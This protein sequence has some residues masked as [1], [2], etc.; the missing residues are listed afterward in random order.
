[1]CVLK[2]CSRA[3][4]LANYSPW[5]KS[6][7][8]EAK[9]GHA[10]LV[11][12]SLWW[13]SCH[14]SC[15]EEIWQRPQGQ[16]SQKF[17]PCTLKKTFAVPYSRKMETGLK[18]KLEGKKTKTPLQDMSTDSSWEMGRRKSVLHNGR[19]GELT[20]TWCADVMCRL[21]HMISWADASS[22]SGD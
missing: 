22:I 11:T 17:W 2:Q 1:M 19:Q 10:H 9:C 15:A 14:N 8:L 20:T 3:Q 4:G 7:P 5:A 21:F 16:Q 18:V 13:L 6:R 12:H